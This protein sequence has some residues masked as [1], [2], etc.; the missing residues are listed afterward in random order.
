L[1][2]LD[3]TENGNLHVYVIAAHLC[4]S[5]GLSRAVGGTV[6]KGRA[7]SAGAAVVSAKVAVPTGK[8]IFSRSRNQQVVNLA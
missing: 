8:K 7:G 3:P 6:F 5:L 1:A 2:K 4:E